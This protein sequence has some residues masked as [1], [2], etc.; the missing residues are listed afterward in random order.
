MKLALKT[1]ALLTALCLATP[2]FAVG[3][4]YLSVSPGHN[5]RLNGGD[6]IHSPNGWYRLIMQKDGNL[7]LYG[8]GVGIGPCP[9]RG[10]CA[11]WESHTLFTNSVKPD[12]VF[13]NMQEDGHLVIYRNNKSKVTPYWISGPVQ[14]IGNYFLNVQ[15]DGNVVIYQGNPDKAGAVIW[16]IH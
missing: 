15:N 10:H 16:S 14:P 3:E 11:Q 5:K 13:V 12:S 4:T 2:A 9:F 6:S 7:V 1:V 8:P